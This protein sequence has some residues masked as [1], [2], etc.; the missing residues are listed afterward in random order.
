V[1]ASTTTSS[2]AAYNT[3]RSSAPGELIAGL[4]RYVTN[5]FFS[6]FLNDLGT[7]ASNFMGAAKNQWYQDWANPGFPVQNKYIY[8]QWPLTSQLDLL[9]VSASDAAVLASALGIVDAQGL[10]MIPYSS[11]KLCQDVNQLNIPNICAYKRA[12][13]QL[14]N[15]C[16]PRFRP[17]VTWAST[18]A[19]FTG[20][21]PVQYSFPLP[22][23]SPDGWLGGWDPSPK[24]DGCFTAQG[25]SLPIN[26]YTSGPWGSSNYVCRTVPPPR[27]HGAL[28]VMDGKTYV[29][30]GWLAPGVFTNDL[31]VRDEVLPVTSW[32]HPPETGGGKDKSTDTTLTVACSEP[33][34]IFEARF[35]DGSPSQTGAFSDGMVLLRDWTLIPATYQTLG[36]NGANRATTVQ[37]RAIDAA[38]N[39]D[40]RPIFATWTYVPPFPTSSIIL[41]VLGVLVL[42][43]LAYWYYRRWWRRRMLEWLARRKLQRAANEKE[44]ERRR[45]KRVKKFRKEKQV[46]K[47]RDRAHNNISEEQAAL[48]NKFRELLEVRAMRDRES[49]LKLA[50]R[51]LEPQVVTTL[52]PPKLPI[53]RN[54]M[55]PAILMRD[56][57][58]ALDF[59]PEVLGAKTA[60]EMKKLE[61]T[62]AMAILAQSKGVSVSGLGMRD[63]AAADMFRAG[64][65]VHSD[66]ISA[67]A[68]A[69]ITVDKIPT[70]LARKSAIKE[71][72]K[73]GRKEED[74]WEISHM[75]SALT[76]QET[77]R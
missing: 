31:W 6:L 24:D 25:G 42:L 32:V 48:R 2:L 40:P 9:N 22:T 58:D 35:W 77:A 49:R 46:K 67:N 28:A 75:Q 23:I 62:H 12:A 10:A 76:A 27:S 45:W 11:V 13:Q 41:A 61:R 44:R 71:A 65:G 60:T 70:T 39:K 69:G 57:K 1:G 68:L 20:I 73:A 34:C 26:P 63:G 36:I 14:V 50:E 47:T 19:F 17:W 8:P 55:K 54:V 3:A 29:M 72:R 51:P 18:L 30:G 7:T 5:D 15:F 21:W 59:N 43:I 37:V 56:A 33:G 53:T 66:A 52:A 4:Q 16:T 74:A 38:G 64:L